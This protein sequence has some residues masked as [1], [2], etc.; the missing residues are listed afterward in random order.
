MDAD[1]GDRGSGVETYPEIVVAFQNFA[2]APTNVEPTLW[3]LKKTLLFWHLPERGC[4]VTG[5]HNSLRM[6]P[7]SQILKANI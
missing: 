1:P 5:K 4:E 7:A 3:E 2:T 6:S